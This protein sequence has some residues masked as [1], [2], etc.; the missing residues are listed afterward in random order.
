LSETGYIYALCN[1][2]G[3]IR[4]IGQTRQTLHAR[5]RQHVAHARRNDS[6]PVLKWIRQYGEPTIVAVEEPLLADL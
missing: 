1:A 6:T 5:L 4:Y 3:V 2:G